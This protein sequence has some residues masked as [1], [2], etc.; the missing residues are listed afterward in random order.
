VAVPVCKFLGTSLGTVY[1][2]YSGLGPIYGCQLNSLEESRRGKG[3]HSEKARNWAELP[4]TAVLRQL[5]KPTVL[6]VRQIHSPLSVYPRSSTV[7]TLKL[8]EIERVLRSNRLVWLK[9]LGCVRI[10]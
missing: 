10:K 1:I 6:V 7:L 2:Y 4:F 3:N 8:T 9:S 5:F